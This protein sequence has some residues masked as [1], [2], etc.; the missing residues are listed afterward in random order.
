MDHLASGDLDSLSGSLDWVL[1]LEMLQRALDSH[2]QL[3]WQSPQLKHLDHLYSSLDPADGLYWLRERAGGVESLV[4]TG[5]I[6]RFVYE[7]PD[8]T[9]AWTRAMLLRAAGAER[10]NNVDWDRITL[11][12]PSSHGLASYQ[13]LWM[14]DPRQ[15]T[16]AHTEHLFRQDLTLAQ[17]ADALRSLASD[18]TTVAEEGTGIVAAS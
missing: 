4:S 9:R 7:P 3:S 8:D 2:A 13:V 1:K 18:P 12:I 17:L 11:R 14:Q 5:D 16:R 15:W 10:V 6:E